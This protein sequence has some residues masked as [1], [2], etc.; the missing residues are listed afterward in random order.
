MPRCWYPKHIGANILPR[1]NP[2]RALDQ[3]H[4][5][6]QSGTGNGVLKSAWE[7]FSQR[8]VGGEL[9][10]QKTASVT[11]LAFSVHTAGSEVTWVN[12]VNSERAAAAGAFFPLSILCCVPH[13][14]GFRRFLLSAPACAIINIYCSAKC[15]ITLTPPRERLECSTLGSCIHLVMENLIKSHKILA[16]LWFINN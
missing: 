15:L 3:I 6:W 4:A 13:A 10:T 1:W 16:I 8:S 12:S 9:W 2:E 14:L 5:K 7:R 11:S